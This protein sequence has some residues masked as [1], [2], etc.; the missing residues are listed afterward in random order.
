M[1]KLLLKIG[2]LIFIAGASYATFNVFKSS[3]APKYEF[4]TATRGSVVQDVVLTGK[5]QSTQTVDLS[6]ESGGKVKSVLVEVGDTVKAGNTLLT[7]DSSEQALDLAEAQAELEVELSTLREL[8]KGARPEEVLVYEAKL[9]N[10]RVDVSSA[11]SS[12]ADKMRDSFT[13]ADDSIRNNVDQLFNNPRSSS[14]QLSITVSNSQLENDIEQGRVLLESILASLQNT[15]SGASSGDSTLLFVES[16]EVTTSLSLIKGFLD[17]VALAVNALSSSSSIS[18]TTVDAYKTSISTARATINTTVSAVLTAEEKARATLS[19]VSLAEKEL[20][21]KKA[22][23]T[24]EQISSQEAKIRQSQARIARL[25]VLLDKMILRTPIDGVV[26]RQDAKVGGGVSAQTVVVSI[27][28]ENSLE[29][30]ANI[31]EVDLGRVRI[32]NGVVI[33][34]DAFPGETFSG[35]VSYIDPA[36]TVIDGVV[37]YKSKITFKNPDPRLKS[38]LTANLEIQSL[39]KDNVI[40]LPQLAIL[41]T[42]TG[43]FVRK[44][45][46]GVVKDV[47]VVLGARD[48]AGS[49]EIVSGVS[50]GDKVINV[51]LRV[52]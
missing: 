19:A 7:L 3:Q 28:T 17:K 45:E 42:D 35:T 24:T 41:E 39:K 51:G 50:E 30:E 9:S 10:A 27:I 4:F 16:R 22:G 14:P 11:L 49:V 20:A 44:L 47:S 25:R 21:L 15:T 23:A 36:E 1:T 52:N 38:G 18:Q 34:V 37:N 29:I 33:T 5:T 40:L 12:L 48:R 31:P 2:V 32:G 46:N 13:K 6:F 43:T 8:K 26:T